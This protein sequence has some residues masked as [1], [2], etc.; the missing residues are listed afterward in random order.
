M[1][2]SAAD[3]Q[4]VSTLTINAGF[5]IRTVLDALIVPVCRQWLCYNHHAGSI[6][7]QRFMYLLWFF[8]G[9]GLQPVCYML[10]VPKRVKGKW[11]PGQHRSSYKREGD[12]QRGDDPQRR[13]R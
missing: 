7:C 9:S 2:C 8:N 6:Q 4:E 13:P 12:L 10:F 1:S 11:C 5:L 3:F